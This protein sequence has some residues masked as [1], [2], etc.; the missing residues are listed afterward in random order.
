MEREGS[1]GLVFPGDVGSC[2]HGTEQSTGA[3]WWSLL[4]EL[5]GSGLSC[6]CR[7]KCQHQ[8]SISAREAKDR[9]GLVNGLM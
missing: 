9:A 1:I 8:I 6:P 3:S 7:S 5:G 2:L 4:T